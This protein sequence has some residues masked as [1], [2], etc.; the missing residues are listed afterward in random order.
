MTLM[1]RLGAI[2]THVILMALCI[3]AYLY[4]QRIGAD[5]MFKSWA[6]YGP[7]VADGQ[8]WRIITGGFVH[9]NALHLA[10]NMFSLY[11]L[12][13]LV[14]GDLDTG[15]RWRFA[16]LCTISLLGGSAGVLLVTF[17]SP[18]VGISGMV[19][20]LLAAAVAIPRRAGL[21]IN[22][23][24][25]MPWVALNLAITF[26]VPGLS[27]GGHVGGLVAGFVAAWF[28]VPAR[29]IELAAPLRTPQAEQL[30]GR[31]H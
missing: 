14:E 8:W 24:K 16:A 29:L 18:T 27:I 7:A 30:Q 11:M 12:G 21:S 10:T 17:D 19:F 28:L 9:L 26:V 23:Y 1:R 5:A 22:H 6:L 31:E 2:R 15:G 13:R 20:G 25:A 4:Q 3:A